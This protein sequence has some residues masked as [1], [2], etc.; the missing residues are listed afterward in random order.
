M[1]HN[2]QAFTDLLGEARTRYKDLMAEAARDRRRPLD[3]RDDWEVPTPRRHAPQDVEFPAPK[4]LMT[5]VLLRQ[6][7]PAKPNDLMDSRTE[8]LFLQLLE[9]A[10]EG[11]V[12]WWYKNGQQGSEHLAIPYYLTAEAEAAGDFELFY[13]DF[14]VLFA[15]GTL[16]IFDPK[17]AGSDP[18]AVPK[19]NALVAYMA[20][21]NALGKRLVGGIVLPHEGSWR[22]ATGPITSDKDNLHTWA[23]L[24]L[25]AWAGAA[26][27][28][29]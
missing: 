2:Q 8:F 12:Q 20:E 5:P 23:V 21:Q 26:V 10:P 18:A 28:S 1:L 9:A 19:H 6:R 14:L 13:P 7:D 11:V 29:T 16:G 24:Q 15:D 4:S 25:T 27:S 3:R 22:Y 17:T